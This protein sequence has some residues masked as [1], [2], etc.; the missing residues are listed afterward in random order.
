AMSSMQFTDKATETLNAAAKYAA[1]NSHV[2]LHP[3]HVAVVMLDEENSLFRSILEKAGGDVVSI[4]RGFKKIMVRQPS[5]DPPPTEMGHSPELAK[6]LHYAHEH[7]KKQRDLYIAQ[8]HLILA[9]ADLPSMAQVLKEGGVTKKSLENAVTHVRGNRRVESKSAEEAY[10]ALSKYCIDLTELAASGKLDPVIGRDE[11]ISRVIRVLSRRTKNNPCLVGEPGVGKTAIA[12]GLAN[13]I[14]KGDI[15]S[16]LQKKVYS[17]DIGSLLAGAKYRGEFEERLKAVL[18]ELKE[19]QAIVFID[20]IHTVLGAGKSE[21]A[22]DAANLLKPMLARGELRCIGAT[23]LTEY[24]QYVEKD[25]AFE[26]RFQLV[27]VEEP[28]VTD[29]ISIL[30]GLKERYETHHGVRIAD[31]AIVAAA[32]LAARYITQRFMPDK[33]IDL[34]D[35]ACANTRVQLDSQP[36]AIDKLERRHLQLEVEATAL[37]KEKDAASKQRLQEVRAEMARIQE[38][39]RPLKMKYESEKGRLDEIRNLSQ[40]LDELKAKA[41]DAE[42]RYDLARAADIRYYAIPDLEKRL[43]QLQAEKSQ[44]DAERADGLLAEVVGPDQ[45]MEVV[46]RWT[47]IPVSNL[48]RSE[49]EKLLHMEEYMKQHVV[50][51]DEAI[52]AICDAIRLSRTG[53]QNRNRP[54]ASF[55]FLGPTGCGKT[56]CVKELAAFLFNDPGAIV[57][58]DMSE[59]MEK[60]AVSRLVGAPPGYIGHDE[61][62]QLTEAVRRR[63]Y[64]V[65]LFD[66]ME[67]AHKDVS[68]LL[69]Q[70]LDDGHCTDSKGRRVD[71]KNTIIVMTSNLGADL[72]ELDE[73]DKVSQA[74]KNAVLATARRHFANEF[75]N[76]ID[77][78]IVFN[79][80]T[81]SNIRKIVDVRLKEVQERLDE[82]QITLDVDDKAKDLL[83]QQGFDPVYGA[84]PLNRLI[85]HALLTQLS[86]LLLDGGVRPGEIAKVTVDQEGEIIVIRNHGI[87]S[88]APWADED[89][90]EDEDMEI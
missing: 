8:D 68:N 43:A 54:L 38:E 55:L 35:E 70:I 64:T 42:R 16:S 23:T 41:E 50:G 40:R 3:S 1:E 17:L 53:L 56:L 52:K 21:G 10:E 77:E 47:G 75:I 60:H 29:T 26:R 51:Q 89:M 20:E 24:R 9:L 15:P 78:L 76:R 83:A 44:A 37:E 48:Q 32:Q 90:V 7:M 74:T 12:E 39:L 84:R 88:P 2:Q 31:A 61:G 46:S 86:R 34:I 22:I 58:I 33:A 66:E 63:P 85:Q 19:A 25:P 36:E 11:I 18:K 14:V 65:V 4:E 69:L 73:G 59:Y 62:G 72:F 57:R 82:K 28:S 27:M 67:K 71:F 13:R 87:E 79:R 45:I 49:K 81:P 30:R 80:L 5:Q 6:L